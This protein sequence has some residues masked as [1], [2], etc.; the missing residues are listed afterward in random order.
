MTPKAKQAVEL[1]R[2][3]MRPK[4]IAER[5][6]WQVGSVYAALVTARKRGED[7]PK[8][9]RNGQ[10]P[11]PANDKATK[12]AAIAPQAVALAK[13]G[14]R[15]NQIAQR[16]GANLTAVN[17]AVSRARKRGEHIP[18]HNPGPL[19][20]SALPWVTPGWTD[21]KVERALRLRQPVIDEVARALNEKP[22]DLWALWQTGKLP[23]DNEKTIK[24][25]RRKGRDSAER[26]GTLGGGLPPRPS[27]AG[28]I[29][30]AGK[31][32]VAPVLMGD[33]PQGRSALEL[34]KDATPAP[35]SSIRVPHKKT[36]DNGAVT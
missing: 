15:P 32:D 26:D 6:D 24:R 35:V 33:P 18:R 10:P 14:M 16:L 25:S 17:G 22:D 30:F 12:R 21:A 34:E 7:I 11:A 4:Q 5:L 31:R 19:P 3:G 9:A 1:A 36:G 2:A 23:G 27:G 8:F 20:A 28:R 29:P 13:T